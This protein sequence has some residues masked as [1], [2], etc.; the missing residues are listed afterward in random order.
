MPNVNANT[1]FSF[2]F[3]KPSTCITI[4][5]P[6]LVIPSSLLLSS[7]SVLSSFLFVPCFFLFSSIFRSHIVN[8]LDLGWK[9]TS[10]RER[11]GWCDGDRT[12]LTKYFPISWYTNIN[13]PSLLPFILTFFFFPSFSFLTLLS[14]LSLPILPDRGCDNMRYGNRVVSLHGWYEFQNPRSCCSGRCC[15]R[16]FRH[17]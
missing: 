9:C 1:F 3:P 17:L 7:S 12:P 16:C 8:I 2:R 14:I 13:P 4:H 5:Q 6:Y 11:E 15:C 10:R